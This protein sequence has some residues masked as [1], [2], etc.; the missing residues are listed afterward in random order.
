MNS[1]YRAHPTAE[2]EP[3]AII[4]D[5][6]TLWRFVHVMAGAIVGPRVVLGQGC[7]VAATARIGPGCR[8]QNNVSLYDGV[9]LEEDVFIG[10]SAVFTNVRRPRAAFATPRDRFAP[11]LVR[12]GASV[13]ANATIVCGV[14]I[15]EGAMIG[16]G[17]VVTRDVPP[18]TLAVG[19]P[20][21]VVGLVCACGAALPGSL[22][23]SCGRRYRRE[24]GGLALEPPA[25]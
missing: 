6:A 20:A 18:Y 1:P 19:Q 15:G 11:T 24:G 16:A 14:T 25:G 5:G 2:I 3:G 13:G 8:V 22:G 17:A 23:C 12:R 9:T 7:F 4:G 21:R 10:P